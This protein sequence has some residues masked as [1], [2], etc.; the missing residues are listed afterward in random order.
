MHLYVHAMWSFEFDTQNGS[1][2]YNANLHT[3]L[4]DCY[5]VKQI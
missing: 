5:L 2:P 4:H 3:G 1:L